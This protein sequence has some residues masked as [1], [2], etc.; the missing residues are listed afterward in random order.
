MSTGLVATTTDAFE[1]AK[2]IL[3]RVAKGEEPGII[4]GEIDKDEVTKAKTQMAK[5][6]QQALQSKKPATLNTLCYI[7]SVY[8]DLNYALMGRKFLRA[9]SLNNR[10]ACIYQRALALAWAKKV[11]DES[12]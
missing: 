4:Y 8:R 2:N 10:Q 9:S 1:E 6:N 7:G 12:K 3:D 5:V 11:E